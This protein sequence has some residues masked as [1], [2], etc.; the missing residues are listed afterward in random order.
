VPGANEQNAFGD[1][2]SDRGEAFGLF[3][4]GDFLQFF[5]VSNVVEGNSGFGFH[6]EAGRIYQFKAWLVVLLERRNNSIKAINGK[7]HNSLQKPDGSSTRQKTVP[8]TRL[9]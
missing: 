4:E 8:L 7:I 5:F 3:E 6:L 9:C 2:R 1:A